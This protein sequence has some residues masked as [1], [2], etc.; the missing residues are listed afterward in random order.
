MNKFGISGVHHI[1][2]FVKNIE[3]AKKM[4]E[5][6][7][8][9]MQE[10]STDGRRKVKLSFGCLDH[11]MVELVQ[12]DAE[13]SPVE[14]MKKRGATPYHICYEVEDINLSMERF[15]K[16]YKCIPLNDP[17]ESVIDGKRVVHLYSRLIGVFELIEKGE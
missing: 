7:G 10:I 9:E 17:E 4:F 3:K 15:K 12:S 16:E 6:M 14:N 8:Y 2:Y 13:D 1:G 5:D 11:T